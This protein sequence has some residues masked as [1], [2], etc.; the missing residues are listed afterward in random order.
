LQSTPA[1]LEL[2]DDELGLL[3]GHELVG[4]AVHDQRGKV[5]TGRVVHG[6]DLAADLEDSR[7]LRDRLEYLGV[8]V[9]LVKVEGGLETQ[10]SQHGFSASSIR[11]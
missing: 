7:F 3:D 5:V 6:A 4:V 9:L 8:G 11:R 2:V 10:P 1:R